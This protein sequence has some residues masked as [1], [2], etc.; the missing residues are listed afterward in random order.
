M[1]KRGAR[2][3]GIAR[4]LLPWSQRAL[5]AEHTGQSRL[6]MSSIRRVAWR[7]QAKPLWGLARDRGPRCRNGPRSWG[8]FCTGKTLFLARGAHCGF[9][10][11]GDV[12]VLLDLSM[13]DF[14]DL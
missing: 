4:V 6:V 14:I 5:E 11:T 10:G 2:T 1:R 9:C 13:H 8:A 3:G 12:G 7:P